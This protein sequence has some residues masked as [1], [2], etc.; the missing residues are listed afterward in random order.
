MAKEAPTVEPEKVVIHEQPAERSYRPSHTDTKT[1]VIAVGASLVL[2]VIGLILGYL[3]G[4][5]TASSARN[6]APSGS[7][8][9][10]NGT[11]RN[12][13]QTQSTTN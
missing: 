8:M 2:F 6:T 7:G 10:N 1:V 12:Q 9:M 11:F 4:H 5:Q 13:T 3:L